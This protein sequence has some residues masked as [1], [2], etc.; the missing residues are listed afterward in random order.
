MKFV[1]KFKR[2]NTMISTDL[3]FSDNFIWLRCDLHTHT[4]ASH[5]THMDGVTEFRWLLAYMEAG[6]DIIAI[7]DH[8][9]GMWID[10]VKAAYKLMERSSFQG[11]R[12]LT[13]FPGVEVT[14][15]EGIHLLAIF[16]HQ[17]SSDLVESFLDEIRSPR[18]MRGEAS[19]YADASTRE[20]I[21]IVERARGIA[22]P[23]HVD[24]IKGRGLFCLDRD[25]ITMLIQAG[26]IHVVESTGLCSEW[27]QPFQDNPYEWTVIVGSDTH[28]L[29][30]FDPISRVPGSVYTRLL[31]KDTT[32]DSM[33]SVFRSGNYWVDR[34]ITSSYGG[35]FV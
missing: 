15:R 33:R 27:Q 9:T 17:H 32:L 23:A 7:T 11:F 30:P 28:S 5:D 26:M 29:D 21:S 13:I 10:R 3:N 19:C 35:I 2:M 34:L 8:N 4:P 6:I 18:V 20:I 1:L 12:P 31:L 16:E 25:T 24:R 22:I 14:T